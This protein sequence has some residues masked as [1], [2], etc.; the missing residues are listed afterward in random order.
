MREE[1]NCEWKEKWNGETGKEETERFSVLKI[2]E[3]NQTMWIIQMDHDD[4]DFWKLPTVCLSRDSFQE[5][6]YVLHFSHMRAAEH[7]QI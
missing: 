4:Y 5:R 2:K 3:P 1:Q 6:P 7:W